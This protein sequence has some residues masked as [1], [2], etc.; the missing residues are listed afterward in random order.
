MPISCAGNGYPDCN[1]RD[2]PR[3]TPKMPPRPDL[4]N[5]FGR[6][7]EQ[8]ARNSEAQGLCGP[9]IEDKLKFVWLLDGQICGLSAFENLPDIVAGEK[10]DERPARPV[11]H[12]AA[13]NYELS[14]MVHGHYLVVCCQLHYFFA[15]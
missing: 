5:Q 6:S 14:I 8:S 13:V 12:Q 15:I 4:C 10:A 7:R 11:A 2:D 9:Q 3:D 1:V